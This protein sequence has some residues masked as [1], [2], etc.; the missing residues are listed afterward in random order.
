MTVQE[1]IISIYMKAKKAGFNVDDEFET[2]SEI[3]KDA[4]D[5][6]DFFCVVFNME[7]KELAEICRQ[8]WKDAW[9]DAIEEEKTDE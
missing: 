1:A 5:I 9:N 3:L 6:N 8:S 7:L 2:L 4:Q